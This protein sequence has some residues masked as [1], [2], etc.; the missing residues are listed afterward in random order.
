MSEEDRL[1]SELREWEA[2]YRSIFESTSDA[3]LILDQDGRI[4]EANP[5]ACRLYGYSRGELIGLS[6]SP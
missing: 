3:L 4:I 5:A 6:A 2:Q 1:M